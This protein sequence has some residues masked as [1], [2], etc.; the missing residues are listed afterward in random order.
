[1]AAKHKKFTDNLIEAFTKSMEVGDY[2]LDD[3]QRKN[4]KKLAIDIADSIEKFIKDQT[5]QITEMKAIL[6]LEKMKTA[7]PYKADIRPQV[8]VRKGTQVKTTVNTTV[9]PGIALVAAGTA[10]ATTATGQGFGDGKG[11]ATS[12]GILRGTNNGVLIPKVNFKKGGGQG[13][14]LS[15]K[16]YAYVGSN[17]VGSSPPSKTKV[18][19]T[20]VKNK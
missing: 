13:G 8:K 11:T 7:G 9:A 18:Q 19:L 20:K 5:F 1:M 17:P 16:G 12:E 2:T 15:T 4:V 10:G 14:N 6:E 3:E